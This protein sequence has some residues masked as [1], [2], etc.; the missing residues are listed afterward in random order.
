[1]VLDTGASATLA[2]DDARALHLQTG[3]GFEMGGTCAGHVR[4]CEAQVRTQD[5]GRVSC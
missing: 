5:L 3:H 4:A 1:M 2:D